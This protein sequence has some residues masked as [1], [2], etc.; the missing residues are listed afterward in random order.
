MHIAL[1]GGTVTFCSPTCSTTSSTCSRLPRSLRSCWREPN[2]W[3]LSSPAACRSG[4]PPR[5]S[6]SC[7]RSTTRRRAT[8]LRAGALEP[9]TPSLR[10]ARVS[11]SFRSQ[12]SSPRREGACQPD[13][14][15]DRL[16]NRLTCWRRTGCR[17]ATA[18][19]TR[20]HR[21]VL[22]P[23][24]TDEQQPFARR[25]GFAG[26]MSLEA[27]ERVSDADRDAPACLRV[28]GL[29]RRSEN[30]DGMFET[31]SQLAALA[32]STRLGRTTT[33][34]GGGGGE[35]GGGLRRRHLDR[36]FRRPRP[37][38]RT[39]L[40]TRALPAAPLLWCSGR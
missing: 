22:R 18:D 5:P 30:R 38:S 20:H 40:A 15:L 37:S 31:S 17:S 28:T 35:V 32:D 14:L 21:V 23:A 3:Y 29:I 26:G 8:V 2:L 6:T 24:T 33:G 36:H 13:Q 10:S 39:H 1:P 16:D 7:R 4:S 19:S 12:S 11:T 34:G 27:A 9:T 25:G